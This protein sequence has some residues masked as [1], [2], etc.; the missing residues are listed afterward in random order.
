MSG[1][2]PGE[3]PRY[4]SPVILTSLEIDPAEFERRTGWAIKP[5]GACKDVRCVP[6]PPGPL[7]AATLEERLGMPLVHDDETDL[8]ALGPESGGRAL[9]SAEAPDFALPDWRGAEFRLRDLR[10]SKVL[11]ISWASW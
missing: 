2:V 1:S 3:R 10:G 7:T 8:Y 4:P 5:E 6:L 9:A 11:I